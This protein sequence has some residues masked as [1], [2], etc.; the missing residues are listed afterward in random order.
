MCVRARVC[1]FDYLTVCPSNFLYFFYQPHDIPPH[2]WFGEPMDG[3]AP[4]GWTGGVEKIAHRL[5]PESLELIQWAPSTHRKAI[6]SKR[7]IV[8]SKEAAGQTQHRL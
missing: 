3:G 1:H 2:G 6:A 7:V 4:R 5:A 8:L